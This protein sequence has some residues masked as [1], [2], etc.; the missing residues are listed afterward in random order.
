M[1]HDRYFATRVSGP[2]DFRAIRNGASPLKQDRREDGTWRRPGEELK[3][4][5]LSPIG[6]GSAIIDVS[7]V[8]TSK[9]EFTTERT[10]DH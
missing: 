1:G 3:C 5:A 4:P 10:K 7:T 9:Q 2:D 6:A 8:A